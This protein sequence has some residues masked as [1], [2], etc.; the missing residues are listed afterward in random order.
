[1]VYRHEIPKRVR[2]LILGGG[3]HGVGLLHDLA[4]R[5]LKDI[6]LLEKDSLAQGTSSRSTK[7]IHGGLRYLKRVSDFSLVSESLRE[8]K[9]LLDLVPDL[10]HPLELIFPILNRGGESSLMVKLGLS[11][12][13]RLAGKEKVNTHTTVQ[14]AEVLKKTPI[15]N[16]SEFKKFYSFWDAQTDDLALVM[17]AANSAVAL[18]GQISEHCKAVSISLS[19]DGFDVEVQED[20]GAVKKISALYVVNCLGPWANDFLESNSIKPAFDGI[21]NKGIH[22][23]LPDKGLKAGLFL[24]SPEDRRIFFLLPW[25]DHTLLGTTEKVFDGS[26]D[27]VY[28]DDEDIDYL[29]ERCNRY[30]REPFKKSEIISSFAGLRWLAMEKSKSISSTS[31]EFS[32]GEQTSGRGLLITLYGGKLTSYRSLAEKIGDRISSHF[33]EFRPSQTHKPESW[34]KAGEHTPPQLLER[35]API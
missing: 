14:E 24:Q 10:V 15:L 35:F 23:L 17:R 26:P 5:G 4:S 28:A 11:L 32:L 19:K 16:P 8:R 18:G 1:M 12:Y 20:G 6:F 9:L 34:I 2:V 13:D 3:I 21:K 27:A 30:L 22:L 33:G 31:R 7:L 29:L 25:L